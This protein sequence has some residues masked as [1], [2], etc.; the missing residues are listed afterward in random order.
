MPSI[1]CDGKTI[2]LAGTSF[3]DRGKTSDVPGAHWDKVGRRWT[4]PATPLSA[5]QVTESFPE[6]TR[7]SVTNELIGEWHRTVDAHA[8]LTGEIEPIEIPE[9][10]LPLWNHQRRAVSF[11]LCSR[12]FY[13]ALDMG[14]GKT[15][16]AIHTAMR[17]GAK[18][19]LITCPLT[20]VPVWPN[21]FKK[22]TDEPV[23]V[24]PLHHGSVKDKKKRAVDALALAKESD[25]VALVINHESLW[26]EPFGDWAVKQPWD[27]VVVDEC[28]PA[29]TMISMPTGNLAIED[30]RI[31]DVVL[32]YDDETGKVVESTVKVLFANVKEE[33]PLVSVH[34]VRMTPNHPV[35]TPVMGY[36]PAGSFFDGMCTHV[37]EI[38]RLR[39]G[40]NT[41]FHRKYVHHKTPE[42]EREF[43]DVTYNIETSTGNYFAGGI[44][45]HNCHRAKSPGGRF[46]MY[47]S[48]L[49]KMAKKRLALS[50][51]P[52]PH[53]P[54]DSYGQWRFLDPAIYGT[55]YTRFRSRFAIM[56]GFGNYQVVGWQNRD[57]YKRRYDLI[58]YSVKSSDVQ[59]LPETQ[60][61]SI[62]VE[63]SDA[64]MN[65]Y[66]QLNRELVAEVQA[67]TVTVANAL[68]K[69]LRLSQIT[70]GNVGTDQKELQQVGTSKRDALDDLVESVPSEEPVVVF[71][72]FVA[73]ID[74]VKIVAKNH[75]RRCY[76]ITGH[77]KELEQW[78]S[79]I[80]ACKVAG[81][82]AMPI[83]AVNIQSGGL[84]IDLT[85]A[86]ICVYF[87]LGYSLGDYTQSL[88]RTH[89][90]GQTRRVLYYHLLASGTVDDEIMRALENKQDVIEAMIGNR[91]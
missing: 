26:R 77:A 86:H 44:L 90:P 79:E 37:M 32:G 15:A 49:G 76:E 24:V 54:L 57:E 83:I 18:R 10:K 3:F 72:R 64:E 31:G 22:H 50:G 71:T 34:G 39:G 27:L 73:D 30:L 87:S 11:A 45:V 62:P 58:C 66:R 1:T 19:I 70:G 85:A 59:D 36:L 82:R 43:A 28:L 7:D 53:S 9:A 4:Y 33:Q 80:E 2:Y 5:V 56:G 69:L 61:I 51:T 35:W 74:A 25:R 23:T 42:S 78:L 89:R 68:T 52:I 60:H 40:N 67:G 29:G 38:R 65:L 55:N 6:A 8:F 20:V 88:K 46:S 47:L 13:A 91:K 75:E 81:G 12:A 17:S 84:G 21:E 16:V 14:C 41:A 63:L 48:K